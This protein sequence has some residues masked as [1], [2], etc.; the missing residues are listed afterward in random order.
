MITIYNFIMDDQNSVQ[1]SQSNTTTIQNEP[2][3]SATN[4][5]LLK[6]FFIVLLVLSVFIFAIIAFFLTNK[7]STSHEPTKGQNKII[8][9][10]TPTLSPF[11]PIKVEAKAVPEMFN[12]IRW[13]L[14]KA[15]Q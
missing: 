14:I 11:T 4:N 2:T 7:N 13:Q 15:F 3:I 12:Y 1:V 6:V 10:P 8:T 9:I 5:K